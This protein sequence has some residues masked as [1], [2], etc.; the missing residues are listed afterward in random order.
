VICGELDTG[1]VD[2]SKHLASAIPGATLAMIPEAGH[3]PQY[4]RPELFNA[5]L[6]AHLR[7]N[8]GVSAK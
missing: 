5:A 8:A 2:A 1:L 3:S 6:A 4:E 7:A